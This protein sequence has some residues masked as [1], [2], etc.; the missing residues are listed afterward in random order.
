MKLRCA[1]W[2]VLF[3]FFISFA[4]LLLLFYLFILCLYPID[5]CKLLVTIATAHLALSQC[6]LI[7]KCMALHRRYQH[8]LALSLIA[9]KFGMWKIQK[10]P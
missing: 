5:H 1:W 2:L 7:L 3:S 9:F 6:L 8:F 4:H 10:E